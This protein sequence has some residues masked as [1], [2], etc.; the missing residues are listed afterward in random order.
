MSSLNNAIQL[1][2]EGRKEEARKILELIL[3]SEPGNIQAW[4]WYVEA[5]STTAQ[6]GALDWRKKFKEATLPVFKELYASV[7]S[8][9]ES[10]RV[11]DTCSQP[12]YR[13]KLDAE[14]TEMR[15][16]ELWQAGKAV[17]ALRP[18]RVKEPVV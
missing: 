16:S 8:G 13:E 7:A 14:L 4:F 10:Q 6:R 12:D 5:C 17:R 18:G 11:I 1:I 3:R 9:Q 15:E 2:R